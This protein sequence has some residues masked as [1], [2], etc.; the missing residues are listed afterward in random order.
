MSSYV[1]EGTIMCNKLKVLQ[2]NNVFPL[3]NLLTIKKEEDNVYVFYNRMIEQYNKSFDTYPYNFHI[4]EP[5]SL[6]EN[7]GRVFVNINKIINHAMLNDCKIILNRLDINDT[8]IIDAV[9]QS[10]Y[11]YNSKDSCNIYKIYNLSTDKD[12]LRNDVKNHTALNIQLGI[13]VICKYFEK[14]IVQNIL[15]SHS[16]IKTN[17]IFIDKNEYVNKHDKMVE[18]MFKLNSNDVIRNN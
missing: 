1:F 7:Q 13:V 3:L 6:G 11:L 2:R 8:D 9:D 15:K 18:F 14:Y 5:T 10:A 12:I 16:K 17:I 4:V